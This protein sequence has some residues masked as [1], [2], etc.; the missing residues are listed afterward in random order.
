MSQ[1]E[2]KY[3]FSKATQTLV[4][5]GSLRLRCSPC[6]RE[7]GPWQSFFPFSSGWQPSFAL[8]PNPQALKD[9]QLLGNFI[10][11]WKGEAETPDREKTSVVNDVSPVPWL[12]WRPTFQMGPWDDGNIMTM[13]SGVCLYFV[14][15]AKHS[16]L[17]QMRTKP[18]P[19]AWSH[20]APCLTF[21]LFLLMSSFVYLP[22]TH[23][24]IKI[25]SLTPPVSSSTAVI[26]MASSPGG[27]WGSV[28]PC[29]SLSLTQAGA[30][31]SSAFR[32]N[33]H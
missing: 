23:V 15:P 30:T 24:L 8:S 26:L 16:D 25:R 12:E 10:W 3:P 27:I 29:C 13:V 7:A 18:E 4:Q 19:G 21:R 28:L 1:D 9:F 5:P 32:R 31:H 33:T 6:L 14:L 20:R 22:L 17:T 2:Q 11:R